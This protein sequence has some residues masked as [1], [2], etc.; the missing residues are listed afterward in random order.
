M[1]IDKRLQD[2]HVEVIPIKTEEQLD[3]T[4]LTTNKEKIYTITQNGPPQ[5]IVDVTLVPEKEIEMD[6]LIDSH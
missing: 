2:I 3:M 1:K 5:D 4:H 6:L